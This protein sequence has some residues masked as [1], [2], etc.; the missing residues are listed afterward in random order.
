MAD[1]VL[2]T[3][4]AKYIHAAFGL[5]YLR[6]NLGS[7]RDRCDIAEFDINQRPLEIAEAILA[8]EPRVVG[9]G[10]YIW[11][12]TATTEVASLLKRIRPEL[13]VVVGGPEVSHE[14]DRQAITALADYVVIGEGEEAFA[15]LCDGLLVTGRK[16][17][18]KVIQGGLPDLAAMALPYD[19]YT[20]ADCAHRVIYVE[21]S[22]GCPFSCEFCLSSLDTK[23]RQFPLEPFLAAMESLMARGVR[24]FKFVD[25]TFNLHIATSKAI[26]QFF[27][28]RMFD[29]LFV[30]FEMVPDRL[31]D[32][33]RGI[34]AQ[35]PPGSL[36]FEIG[37]QTLNPEVEGLISRRQNHAKLRDNLAWLQGETGTHLH[38]DLIV[39]L[40]GEDICSLAR[41]FDDLVGLGVQEIQV[42]ILKRLRG[43]PIARHDQDWRMVYGEHPPYEILST[44][45]ID[46]STMQRLRRFARFWDLFGNS[47]SFG[48][49]RPLLLAGA[50]PFF[51][52][53]A[54]ADWVYAET[55]RTASIALNR[56]FELAWS[57]LTETQGLP[58][59]EV[60]EVMMRDM[61]RTGRTDPLPFLDGYVDREALRL[62]RKAARAEATAAGLPVRQARHAGMD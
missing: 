27:L 22:R 16:P 60:A 10:V 40:P 3:L 56:Q 11:N 14:T 19:E 32:E 50:S 25:R 23:V 52:F 2:A 36:Q 17:L 59:T 21:A 45:L 38:V 43:T 20:P 5:R 62:R 28:D 58:K 34:I 49:L 33:L 35:Y 1:V 42:G 30:H 31:P 6:A 7:L 29:G 53:L 18:T 9:L 54:F 44:K 46:F 26:L 41:G 8:M 51:S 15:K 37:V 12:A 13:I 55:G 4:N 39:G 57:Y 48:L 24:Q 47:G 61:E